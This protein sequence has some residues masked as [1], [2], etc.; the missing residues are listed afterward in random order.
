[1]KNNASLIYNA[2]LAVGDFLALIAAFVAAYILRVSINVYNT[3][4]IYQVHAL[5]FLEIFL[6]LLPFWI[7]IFALLGLYKSNIYERRF[8]ELGRLLLGSFIGMLFV[9]FWNFL[10]VTPIFPA[11]S[12][13][14]IGFIIGFI[15]LVIFRNIARLIRTT[16]FGYNIGI[17]DILIVGN[18][19]ISD[20]LVA[21]LKNSRKSGYRVLGVVGDR[22]R[23][24]QADFASFDEAV[25]AIGDASFHGIIQTELYSSEERNQEILDFAQ[26]HHISYRFIPGNTE[27]FVGNIDVELFRQAIPVINVRQTALFGWGRIVKRL[28]DLFAGALALIITSPLFLLI[29]LL[30]KLSGGEVFF[31]QKRLTRFNSVF[32][33]YKFRTVK[34][35]YNGL[36]PED[37]FAK[38]GKPKLAETYRQNGDFLEHDPRFTTLGRILRK[39]SLDEIPQILNVLRGDVSL[40]GPRALVPEELA[41]YGKRH[42]ILAVKS[43]MT[44]LAVVSGRR[45]IPY[46]ER[47]KLDLYYVQN[48]SFRL[49]LTI[50][51]KT[52]RVLIDR[53]ASR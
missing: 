40:V 38:M 35:A 11:K 37:A 47:R 24:F 42:T 28:F 17:A 39:T 21:A 52:L 36:S 26:K 46:D 22:R 3:P 14:I 44:G 53:T 27:L 23:N 15:F 9:V 50:L 19:S 43:G 29:A 33:V 5:T 41:I 18:T 20:E 13:P 2:C 6:V 48:W 12:I 49:D 25:E 8:G 32:R 34:A 45:D 1:M 30:E 10:Q 4:V 31:R 7:L 16:L 51:I